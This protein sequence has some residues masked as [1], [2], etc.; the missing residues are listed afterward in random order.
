M[1]NFVTGKGSNEMSPMCAA[2]L[3]KKSNSVIINRSLKFFSLHHL[4][5]NKSWI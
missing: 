1:C 5:S 2:F 3:V 4:L